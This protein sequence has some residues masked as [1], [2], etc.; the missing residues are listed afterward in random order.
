M[1]PGLTQGAVGAASAVN[2]ARK[3]QWYV[4]G[5]ILLPI[6]GVDLMVFGSGALRR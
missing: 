6:L 2:K 1:N 4:A 5:G 3:G